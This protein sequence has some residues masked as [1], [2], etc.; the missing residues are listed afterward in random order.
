M[1]LPE[2]NVWPSHTKCGQLSHSDSLMLQNATC[3]KKSADGNVLCTA[4][5]RHA[6]CIFAVLPETSHACPSFCIC[7]TTLPFCS[8]LAR[9]SLHCA[10]HGK[11]HLHVQKWSE[12]P[13]TRCFFNV[14]ASKCASRH[15]RMRFFNSSTSN[16]AP[17]RR[18]F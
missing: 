6:K 10:C 14:L 9:C 16:S 3:L 8:R 11:W 7:C 17:T 4:W 5:A 2:K 1:H 15:S 13:T 18:C 12:L